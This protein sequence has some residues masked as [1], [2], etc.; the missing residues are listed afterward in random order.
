MKQEGKLEERI[1]EQ[2]PRAV[3][4]AFFGFGLA[5]VALG[6]L[7]LVGFGDTLAGPRP[8]THALS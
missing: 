8:C 2:P 1:I 6:L 4:F 7:L 3:Q 5:M